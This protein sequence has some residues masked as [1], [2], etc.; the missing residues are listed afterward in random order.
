MYYLIKSVN[1]DIFISY[2]NQKSNS[3]K[4]FIGNNNV[5]EE[6]GCFSLPPKR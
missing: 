3:L 6:N 2:K 5:Q 1:K 4:V